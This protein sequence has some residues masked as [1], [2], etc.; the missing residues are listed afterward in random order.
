MDATVSTDAVVHTLYASLPP[1]GSELV[2]FDLN[3]SA[4]LDPFIRPS[5]R[6]LLG[7]LFDR[8][9]SRAY[10][11]TV[12]RNVSTSTPEVAEWRVTAGTTTV[13]TRPLGLAWPGDVFSLSHIAMP[14]RADDPVFG[15]GGAADAGWPDPPGHPRTAWR[16]IGVDGPH[17][18]VDARVVQPFLFLS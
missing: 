10:T 8:T 16:A 15:I 11:V 1:N 3:R 6:A 14:F 17:R 2:L 13:V 4:H 9:A 7:T 5:D 18:Y 12:L